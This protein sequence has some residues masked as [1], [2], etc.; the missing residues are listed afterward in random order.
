MLSE[1]IWNTMWK[2]SIFNI[3]NII[4]RTMA[5]SIVI[6]NDRTSVAKVP[7]LDEDKDLHEYIHVVSKPLLCYHYHNNHNLN[8]TTRIKAV[9]DKYLNDFQDNL[10]ILTYNYTHSNT[11]EDV[12]EYFAR[13]IIDSNCSYYQGMELAISSGYQVS[14]W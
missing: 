9:I 3:R 8:V 6:T 10:V 4:L 7:G 2:A 14:D 12:K 13:A 11:F 1:I 5:Y